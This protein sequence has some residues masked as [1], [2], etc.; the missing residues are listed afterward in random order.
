MSL[1]LGGPNSQLAVEVAGILADKDDR[2]IVLLNVTLPRK[3]NP[4]IESFIAEKLTAKNI[5]TRNIRPEYKT[6]RRVID[7]I[8]DESGDYDLVV[9]GASRESVFYQMVLGSIPEEIAKRCKTPL[10][11]VKSNEGVRSFIKRWL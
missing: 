3:S 9:I 1:F 10:I 7:A 2:E 11:M 5:S 6:S 8:L 4:D